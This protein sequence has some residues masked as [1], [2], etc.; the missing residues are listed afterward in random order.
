V[1]NANTIVLQTFCLPTMSRKTRCLS[2]LEKKAILDLTFFVI[3]SEEVAAVLRNMEPNHQRRG[4]AQD[5]VLAAW[6]TR[7]PAIAIG[8][9]KSNLQQRV[10]L[11]NE[12]HTIVSG[13]LSSLAE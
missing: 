2:P 3:R 1:L 10:E 5:S 9:S 12:F 13:R 4:T 11:M 6:K 7:C 8:I